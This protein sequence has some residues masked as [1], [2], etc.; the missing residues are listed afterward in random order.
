MPVDVVI[1]DV[2][3]ALLADVV[4]EPADA[5]QVVRLEEREAVVGA[6]AFAGHYFGRDGLEM[7]VGDVQLCHFQAT[8]ALRTAAPQNSRN[9][10]LI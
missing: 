1:A 7:R 10:K 3:V 5:E 8:G 4:G 6:E 2:A 9:N